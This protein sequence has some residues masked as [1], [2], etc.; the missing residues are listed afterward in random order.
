MKW[1]IKRKKQN[2][3][4]CRGL[5]SAKAAFAE[6]NGHCT[7]QSWTTKLQKYP[8]PSFAER[9]DRCTR[10]RVFFFGKLFAES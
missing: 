10:Q 3:P 6:S 1:K 7:R 4:L 9:N 2:F 8:F 5:L